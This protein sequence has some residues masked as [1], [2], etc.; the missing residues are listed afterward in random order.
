MTGGLAAETLGEMIP[1]S[2][3]TANPVCLSF[4][5]IGQSIGYVPGW[6]PMDNDASEAWTA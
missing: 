4:S 1:F 5:V 3:R 6:I 2:D